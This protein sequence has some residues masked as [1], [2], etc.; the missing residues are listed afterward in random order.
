MKREPQQKNFVI[1][2]LIVL[3]ISYLMG[4]ACNRSAQHN[5]VRSIGTNSSKLSTCNLSLSR[6]IV[7]NL[8]SPEGKE[9]KY[10]HFTFFETDN[11]ES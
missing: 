6:R 3:H 8:H 7:T 4:S 5:A 11:E 2:D 9:V 10:K 1:E